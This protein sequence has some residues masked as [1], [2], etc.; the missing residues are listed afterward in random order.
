MSD[1]QLVQNS[2]LC[3]GWVDDCVANVWIVGQMLVGGWM[4][5]RM[6]GWVDRMSTWM[7]GGKRLNKEVWWSLGYTDE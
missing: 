1:T 6:C 7:D 3:D 2:H 4:G 5:G